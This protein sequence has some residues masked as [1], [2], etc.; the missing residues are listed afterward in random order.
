MWNSLDEEVVNAVTLNTFK[1]KYDKN[2]PNLPIKLNYTSHLT[3]GT[4]R[5]RCVNT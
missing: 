5:N 3:E 2:W 4:G 1:N